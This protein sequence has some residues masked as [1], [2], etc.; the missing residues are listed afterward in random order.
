MKTSDRTVIASLR[1]AAG[2]DWF[3]RPCF[4]DISENIFA[5]GLFFLSCH[6]CIRYEE[7]WVTIAD[8]PFRSTISESLYLTQESGVSSD[9]IRFD[10]LLNTTL[11]SLISRTANSQLPGRKFAVQ[12]ENF[13]VS[14]PLYTLAQCTPD[15]SPAVCSMCLQMAYDVLHRGNITAKYVKPTCSLWYDYYA[16][17]NETAVALLSPPASTP[18]LTPLSPDPSHNGKHSFEN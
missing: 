9:P 13:T 1:V 11:S 10:T 15:L 14:Q 17:Y 5:E 7:C 8:Q 18:A 3:Q 12:K 2:K 4:H 16:F 6:G